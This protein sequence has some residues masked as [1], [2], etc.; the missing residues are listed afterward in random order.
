MCTVRGSAAHSLHARYDDAAAMT[1]TP[2]SPTTDQTKLAARAELLRSLHRPGEPLVLPNAWDAASAH[3]VVDAG[4]PAVATTSRS[5]ERR[6]GKE[7]RSRWS[8]YH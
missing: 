6:V 7:C 1:T 3:T 2:A 8:P 4:F 5:E